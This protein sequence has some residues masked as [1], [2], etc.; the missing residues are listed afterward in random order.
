MFPLSSSAFTSIL[1]ELALEMLV[2][3]SKNALAQ[4]IITASI[5]MITFFIHE[6]NNSDVIFNYFAIFKKL[7]SSCFADI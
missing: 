4:I 2:L 1:V 5:A 3:I 6:S 7:I